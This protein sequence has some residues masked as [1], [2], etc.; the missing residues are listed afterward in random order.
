MTRPKIIGAYLIVGIVY[1]IPFLWQMESNALMLIR[2]LYNYKWI[3][4]IFVKKPHKLENTGNQIK[5][6][7]HLQEELHL[8]FFLYI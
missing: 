7:L 8:Q 6:N 5:F 2:N 4:N 3:I 1:H